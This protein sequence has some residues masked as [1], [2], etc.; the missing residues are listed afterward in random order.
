[1]WKWDLFAWESFL[2]YFIASHLAPLWNR[3]LEHCNSEIAHCDTNKKP[4]AHIHQPSAWPVPQR[5]T[6]PY[7]RAVA[8][9]DSRFHVSYRQRYWFDIL[10]DFVIFFLFLPLTTQS[11]DNVDLPC[12][13]KPWLQEYRTRSGWWPHERRKGSTWSKREEFSVVSS[14]V[15]YCVLCFLSCLVCHYTLLFG[16]ER[17]FTK[18]RLNS[19]S[20]F[21]LQRHKKL[22][23]WSKIVSYTSMYHAIAC[24]TVPKIIISRWAF[25]SQPSAVI[26][27]VLNK[28]AVSWQTRHN[29][30]L[31]KHKLSQNSKNLP[32]LL[33]FGLIEDTVT[34]FQWPWNSESG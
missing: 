1:M 20:W 28:N 31:S 14:C 33:K 34:V 4:G 27:C 18:K 23:N 22:E 19:I 2:Y 11:E 6:T 21:F 32:C 24:L 3:G 29:R 16:R 13:K 26:A 12:S 10:P 15:F 7:P 5:C 25:G 17:K 8:D 9:M 30:K